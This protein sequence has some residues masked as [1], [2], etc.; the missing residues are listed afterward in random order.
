MN[1]KH[2]LLSAVFAFSAAGLVAC[3]GD[4]AEDEIEEAADDIE[5]AA[6]DVGDDI[7][8]AADDVD[9]ETKR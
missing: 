6:D 7:E 1:R 2:I 8:D 4:S 9:D 5:D 3:G